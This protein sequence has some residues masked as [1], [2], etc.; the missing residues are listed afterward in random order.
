MN[1]SSWKPF[2]VGVSKPEFVKSEV[3]SLEDNGAT[4]DVFV[5]NQHLEYCFGNRC[6][7]SEKGLQFTA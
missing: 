5:A 4:V 3:Q 7:E 6:E 2:A 1:L